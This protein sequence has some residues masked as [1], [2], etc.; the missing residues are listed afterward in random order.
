M[1]RYLLAFLL[2]ATL[3]WAL[4]AQQSFGADLRIPPPPKKSEAAK[5]VDAVS[6]GETSLGHH[7]VK[8]QKK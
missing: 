2:G 4:N 3:A 8:G 5:P 6:I 1:N 7:K